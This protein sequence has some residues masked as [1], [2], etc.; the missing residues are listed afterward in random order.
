MSYLQKKFIFLFFTD[1]TNIQCHLAKNS[2]MHDA[3]IIAW[4]ACHFNFYIHNFAISVQL[5]FYLANSFCVHFFTFF[6]LGI[7]QVF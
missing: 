6:P 4:N 2:H 1:T 5:I 7:L 3:V